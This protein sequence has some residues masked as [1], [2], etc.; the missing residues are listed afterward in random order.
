MGPISLRRVEAPVDRTSDRVIAASSIALAVAFLGAAGLSL[1]LP[2]TSRRGLWL[3]LHLALAGGAG[4]AI[5]GV[6]PFFVAA[7]AAAP[8][9][10][11]R[12]RTAAVVAIS[13]GALTV[14]GGV[15]VGPGLV[16]ALGGAA[17]V[18]GIALTGAATLRP[19]RGGLG[20]ARG[21]ITRSYVLA[22]VAV[23]VGATLAT[24]LVAG[25]PPVVVGWGQL[26]L[27]HAWLNLVGFV[28]LVIATTLLHFFPT[29]VGARIPNHVSGRLAV[30]GLAGGA[31][32][33]AL[34]YA[35][36]IDLAA[37]AGA[38]LAL[39][40]AL[41][42]AWYEARVWSTRGR[43]TTDL[44]WH[45]FAIGGLVSATAWFIVGLGLAA[46]PVV[47]LGANAAGWSVDRVLGAL[48]GGWVG[49][50]LLASA[51]HL[52]PA[53][54]PGDPASHARQRRVLGRLAV[55]RLVAL[56]A[57]VALTIVGELAHSSSV[58]PI[59]VLLLAAGYLA[60][61]ALLAMAVAEGLRWSRQRGRSGAR[62]QRNA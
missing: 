23:G 17:F 54:G 30:G 14:A 51:T 57:G 13:I 27:A 29:V 53:V 26:K 32:L 12:L 45:A 34:G 38:V 9:A 3:P 10:D 60:T 24:L 25:W 58:A 28:S 33:A 21:L 39:A 59:G 37:S 52:L 20:P 16:A 40:G 18:L 49:L 5:A 42:L 41:A 8:P 31:W 62:G 61:A 11:A 1:L 15:T 2:E 47:A 4:T 7:F 22:L 44:S 56:D 35:A 48:V 50:A 55:P 19:I 36:R 46:L 6:M 43:W